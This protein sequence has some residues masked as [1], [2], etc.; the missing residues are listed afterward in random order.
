MSHWVSFREMRSEPVRTM[1]VGLASVSSSSRDDGGVVSFLVRS[2]SESS[3]ERA[4]MLSTLVEGLVMMPHSRA[5]AWAVRAKSPV[6]CE[7]VR[8]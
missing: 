2:V 8:R 1:D 3:R 5:M 7:T 4:D 6:T